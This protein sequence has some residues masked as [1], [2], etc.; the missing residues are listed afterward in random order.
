MA[1]RPDISFYLYSTQSPLDE[2][3][4]H[5][6]K[7]LPLSRDQLLGRSRQRAGG[8]SYGDYFQAAC[9][10]I[11]RDDFKVVR[12][13]MANGPRRALAAET[14]R[15]IKICLVKHGAFYHPARIEVVTPER[16]RPFVLNVAVTEAGKNCLETE[17]PLISRLNR[18]F[19]FSYL[20]KVYGCGDAAVPAAGQSLVMFLGEWLGGYHEFHLSRHPIE[21]SDRIRVWHE[22]PE[23]WFL[24][25]DQAAAVYAQAA[26]ILTRYYDAGTFEQIS[27]WHHAAG[28]FVL[29]CREGKMDVRLVTVRHYGPMF[30]SLKPEPSLRMQALLI[31]LLNMSIKM[32]L[33]R[34]DGVGAVVW[35]DESAVKGT[36]KGFFKGLSQKK[37]HFPGTGAP[38][39]A[40]RAFVSDFSAEGTLDLLTDIAD[41]FH[42]QSPDAPV[43]RRHL[44]RHAEELYREIAALNP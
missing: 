7:P 22:Q 8:I 2:T 18:K 43:V 15:E 1:V 10:F 28:D 13:A 37:R 16:C 4:P 23:D 34:R 26:L 12:R 17:Y 19:S 3:S 44:K 25:P 40:F 35:A 9:R 6:T 5:W 39:A 24:T 21:K 42:P 29:K 32:R 27:S 14:L 38:A 36:V 20:P 31:F 11:Q 30:Q 41:R 33:D